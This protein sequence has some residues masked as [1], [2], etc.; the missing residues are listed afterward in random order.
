[1]NVF[2]GLKPD[3]PEDVLPLTDNYVAWNVRKVEGARPDWGTKPVY[4]T[5]EPSQVLI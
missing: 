1:M 4:K 5:V 2:I 3:N